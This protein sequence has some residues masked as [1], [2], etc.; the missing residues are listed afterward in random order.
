MTRLALFI[1]ILFSL[2]EGACSRRTDKLDH[3]YMIPEKELVSILTDIYISDGLLTLP[4]IHDMYSS[5]DSVTAYIQ[6]IEKHGYSKATWDKTLKYYFIRKPK[7]LINIY[8]KVL[9]ILS[10]RESLE[11]KA[12]LVEQARISNL[13]KGKDLY[14][15]PE[16]STTDSTRFDLNLTVAGTFAL[17][18]TT[19]LFPDDQSL[20]TRLNAYTCNA[21][22]L[23]TGK[24]KYVRAI[25]YIKDGRPHTYR[26]VISVPEKSKLQFRGNLFYFDNHPDDGEKHMI[27]RTISFTYSSVVL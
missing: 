26:I 4:K 8:D 10:E 19:T 23:E 1:L 25:N 2:I 11:E 14:Y 9:G 7:T 22:S 16:L 15:Y 17:E 18:F 21:D 12:V 24:K 6:V 27:I 13:W 5:L 3:S 20:N